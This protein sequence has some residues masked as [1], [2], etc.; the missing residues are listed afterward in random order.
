MGRSLWSRP[1]LWAKAFHSTQWPRGHHSQTLQHRSNL[2]CMSNTCPCHPNKYSSKYPHKYL[3]KCPHNFRGTALE[4]C[5]HRCHQECHHR[6]HQECHHRCPLQCLGL[7][8]APPLSL[9]SSSPIR[10]PRSLPP[11]HKGRT[12]MMK[13]HAWWVRTTTNSGCYYF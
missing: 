2:K 10:L 6:R 7:N 13:W 11:L 8:M 4:K 12:S 1:R 9:L 3:S 5:L